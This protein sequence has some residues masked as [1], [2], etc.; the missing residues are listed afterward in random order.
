M[1]HDAIEEAAES[2]LLQERVV[3]STS[4]NCNSFSLF[5]LLSTET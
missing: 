1:G 4:N 2:A 3:N 5:L